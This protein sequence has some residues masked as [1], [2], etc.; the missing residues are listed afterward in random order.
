[1]HR[2]ISPQNILLSRSGEVKIVDFGIAKAT[3]RST[4]TEAGVI[5]GKYYY[6]APEQAWGDPVDGRSDIFSAGIVLHELLTGRMVYKEENLPKLMDK[7][8]KADIRPPSS[9]RKNL[10]K[11]LDEIVMRAVAKSPDDRYQTAYDMAHD[12]REY[13]YQAAP[14]FSANRLADVIRTLLPPKPRRASSPDEAPDD[15]KL[16]ADEF[17]PNRSQS[18]VFGKTQAQ[19]SSPAAQLG[20]EDT[21]DDD[22]EEVSLAQTVAS[23]P[24]WSAADEQ[25]TRVESKSFDELQIAPDA[26][27]K[28][29]QLPRP[30]GIPVSDAPP[31]PDGQEPRLSPAP[32]PFARSVNPPPQ[33]PGRGQGRVTF[34]AFIGI[35]ALLAVGVGYGL[36]SSLRCSGQDVGGIDLISVPPGATV[37][38]NGVETPAPTPTRVVPPPSENLQRSTRVVLQLAGYEDWTYTHPP[39]G[40]AVQKVAVLLPAT[41]NLLLS[42]QPSGAAVRIMNR[43]R[44]TTPVELNNLPLG[45]PLMVTLT[46]DGYERRSVP[47]TLEAGSSPEEIELRLTPINPPGTSP[48]NSRP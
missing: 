22:H 17:V 28:E 38:V 42:S 8:R 11:R 6:M 47:I 48:V 5:K 14:G 20:G 10:P 36:S 15:K 16:K 13:L 23:G 3:G 24:A 25:Q 12:L 39:G 46:L 7:V 26:V 34:V 44:G 41:R 30:A 9:K 19:G 2:D 29:H 27:V 21:D 37:I 45:R 32:D 18:V 43:P 35:I 31:Q 4:K 1:V 40:P 33:S